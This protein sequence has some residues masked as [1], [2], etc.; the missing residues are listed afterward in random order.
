MV[1]CACPDSEHVIVSETDTRRVVDA[2][3]DAYLAGDG[4][5]MLALM[6]HDVEVRFLGQVDLRGRDEARAFFAFSAGL[7]EELD[8]R[9]ERKIVDGEWAAVIWSE[10]A[11]TPAGVPWHNHGVDVFRVREGRISVLHENND[12]R[13]VH[14]YFPRYV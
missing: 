6:A 2:L 5:G 4:E 8:F 1:G 13:L 7:L 11:R 10:T 3:Y 12:V 14:R 9:I